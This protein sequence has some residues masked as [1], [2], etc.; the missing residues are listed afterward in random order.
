MP[1]LAWCPGLVSDGERIPMVNDTF[2]DGERFFEIRRWIQRIPPALE[3]LMKSID[4]SRWYG[5]LVVLLA[6]LAATVSVATGENWPQWRGPDGTGVT[7]E[8]RLPTT[9]DRETNVVW[10]VELPEACNSSPVLW[11]DRVFL[12]QPDSK[13]KTGNVICLRKSDGKQLWSQAVPYRESEATHKTNPYCSPSPVTDG[14]RVIAWFGSAGLVCYDMEGNPQWKLD[15]GPLQHMWGY[16]TSPLIYQDLCILNFGPGAN[17]FLIALNKKTG[18]EVW[19]V[20][21]LPL[22]EEL[23]LSGPENNGN[24]DPTRDKS[25]LDKKLR[26]SWGTPIV[27]SV[28]GMSQLIVAHPRRVTG[29]DPATGRVL[30]VAGGLAPLA[31]TSPMAA[32]GRV[33]ALGGYSGASLAVSTD[34]QGDVTESGRVW[35]KE[36]SIGGWLGTGVVRDGYFYICDMGGVA[37]CFEVATGEER[38]KER[39]PGLGAG[40]ACWSSLT[41]RGD[42]VVYLMTQKGDV[43][44]FEASPDGYRAIARNRMEEGSNSSVAVSDGRLF[45]RTFDALWCI[46]EAGQQ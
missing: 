39:L 27:V 16:G 1:W 34:G 19:R 14:E 40:G 24:V 32:D 11:G 37:H 25:E 35:H 21:R 13:K 23:E 45:L 28:D 20:N 29:Y 33:V 6:G 44:V 15:L 43:F 18:K 41:M 22:E 36:R 5:M 3:F 38:W 2:F 30:W 7:S 31:Y 12:T 4:R 26:G 8:T 10:R 42:G 46:G 17:E 9:W